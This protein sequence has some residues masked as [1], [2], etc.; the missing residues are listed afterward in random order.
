MWPKPIELLQSN[1]PWPGIKY[2]SHKATSLLNVIRDINPTIFLWHKSYWLLNRMQDPSNFH[3]LAYMMSHATRN[4]C[5][6]YSLDETAQAISSTSWEVRTIHIIIIFS[7][8][9]HQLLWHD[10]P[11]EHS[12]FSHHVL[13]HSQSWHDAPIEHLQSLCCASPQSN[14]KSNNRINWSIN[15]HFTYTTLEDHGYYSIFVT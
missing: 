6:H 12:W 5:W 4:H 7:K 11:P 14:N 1:R 10:I 9:E 2:L 3:F 8:F 15:Y 13:E